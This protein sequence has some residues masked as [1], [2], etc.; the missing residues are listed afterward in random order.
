ME[1]FVTIGD[2]TNFIVIMHSNGEYSRYASDTS[3]G[4]FAVEDRYLDEIMVDLTP[5]E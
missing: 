1:L 5:E 4:A 2:H 3:C